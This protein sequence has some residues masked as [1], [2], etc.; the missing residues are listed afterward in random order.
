MYRWGVLCIHVASIGIA[1]AESSVHV[2][3]IQIIL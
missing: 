1:V 2:T 3:A